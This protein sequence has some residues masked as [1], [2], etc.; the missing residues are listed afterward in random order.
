MVLTQ[1]FHFEHFGDYVFL[2]GFEEETVE[3]RV[4]SVQ[5]RQ[6]KTTTGLCAS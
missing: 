5:L 3:T 4:S 1:R 6:N 2:T